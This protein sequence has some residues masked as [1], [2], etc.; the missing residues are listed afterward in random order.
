MSVYTVFD[1]VY[2]HLLFVPVSIC[3]YY[4][5]FN[6]W[7]ES[8]AMCWYFFRTVIEILYIN[9]GFRCTMIM[10]SVARMMADLVEFSWQDR[11]VI[12]IRTFLDMFPNL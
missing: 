8:H 2:V 5:L 4:K 1:F 10:L 6:H 9:V 11:S 3:M 7:R 12:L